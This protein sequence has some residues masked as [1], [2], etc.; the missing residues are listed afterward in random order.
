[1]LTIRT[2]TESDAAE[3]LEIYRPH[4]E[5]S[6]VSFE[7]TV[8]SVAEFAERIVEYASRWSWLVAEE[9]GRCAGY[10]YGSPHRTR[11]AYR[12]SVETSAYV[13]EAYRQR[14]LG[15]RLYA[16]LFVELE[17]KGFRNAYAGITMPNDASVALHRSVGFDDVGVFRNV[18]WKFGAWRDVAWMQRVISELPPLFL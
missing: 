18:G 9:D 4:I 7:T 1:M 8:P 5:D 12:W 6:V 3:L 2:A 11:A 10:A 14:G 16:A 15:K 17:R 13:H